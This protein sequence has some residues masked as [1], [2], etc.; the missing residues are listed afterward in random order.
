[1]QSASTGIVHSERTYRARLTNST[2]LPDFQGEHDNIRHCS[3]DLDASATNPL[4]LPQNNF[5]K[6]EIKP[7]KP[8]VRS[9][10][11]A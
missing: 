2:T 6:E 1:M 7:W 3:A 8:L 9:R 11:P 5:P 10:Q 4:N